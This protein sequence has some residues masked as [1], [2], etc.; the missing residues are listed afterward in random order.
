MYKIYITFHKNVPTLDNCETNE[1]CNILTVSLKVWHLYAW[2]YK[3]HNIK[4]EI[5]SFKHF[6]GEM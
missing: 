5:Y 6:L 4:S 2:V 3:R 1:F